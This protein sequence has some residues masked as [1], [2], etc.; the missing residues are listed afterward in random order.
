[1][2][3]EK[4]LMPDLTLGSYRELTPSLLEKLGASAIISDIDNT[5]ATYDE[6]IACEE[7]RDWLDRV[8]A[9]GVRIAFISNN[10]ED[11]VYMFNSVHGYL[12]QSR[13]GKPGTRK[14]KKL[15]KRMGAERSAA[16][17]IGDQ[18]FT[19]VLCAHRAGIRALMVRS[20]DVTGR[21]FLK[22]KKYF[23]HYFI[24]EYYARNPVR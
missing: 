24:E 12:T 9:S 5:L 22:F 8:E 19:D 4:K 18:I 10:N 11:R 1:M 16:C 14:L 17:M 15:L 23:E 2:L 7:I 6:P 20:M 13:A 21:P 3:F